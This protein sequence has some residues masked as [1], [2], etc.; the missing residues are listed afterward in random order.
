MVFYAC[1]CVCL[2][3]DKQLASVCLTFGK[4]NKKVDINDIDKMHCNT[5]GSYKLPIQEF[6]FFFIYTYINF[7]KSM[8]MAMTN[9]Q[10]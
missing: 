9:I 10:A 4:I 1:L 2:V 8:T 3:V 7:K 5:F 6:F